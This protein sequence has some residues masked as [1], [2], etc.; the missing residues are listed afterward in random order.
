MLL[1]P[2]RPIVGNEPEKIAK[3]GARMLKGPKL[4]K[5]ASH[6]P[7]FVLCVSRLQFVLFCPRQNKQ[8]GQVSKYGLTMIF[9]IRLIESVSLLGERGR[10][11][12]SS[13]SP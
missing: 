3:L 11:K 9:T 10:L 4:I 12:T 7:K 13:V 1:P 5:M 8:T 6:K 2:L